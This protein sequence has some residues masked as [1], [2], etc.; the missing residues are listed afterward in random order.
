MP[1]NATEVWKK[2]DNFFTDALIPADAALDAVVAANRNAELPAID[3]TPLQGKFLELLI[4]ATGAKRVLEMGTLGGYSTIWLARAV[5][6]DG[7]VITLEREKRHAEIAQRNFDNAG[8]A[9]RVELRIG[10]ASKSLAGLVAEKTAPF[11]FIFI[12]ADKASYPEYIDWSLKLS[13]PGTLII[14]DNVVRDGKV[15]DPENPDPNIKGVRRFTEM[16]AAEPRLSATVLQ[17]VGSKGYDGF[18]IAMVN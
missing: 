17:T 16:V 8:V 3:V 13:R 14:A 15:I 4:R 1:K 7:K 12:D 10:P 2:V 18:A 6:E 9:K 11:D 5:G